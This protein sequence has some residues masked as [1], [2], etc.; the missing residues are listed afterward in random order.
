MIELIDGLEYIKSLIENSITERGEAGKRS[1][2]NSSKT[3]N[4]LHEVV[5]SDLIFNGI[6]EDLIKPK[7][8]TSKPEI[9]LAG[10]LK[11]KYQDVCVFPND[12]FKPIPEIIDYNGLH[13]GKK[14]KYGEL[15]S[16]HIL[17]INL[18]SQ[19]SSLSKNKDTMFE[20]TYAEPLNLH[21]RLPKMVLG[22]VYLLSA[23]ELD[24]KAV[25]ENLVSYKPVSNSS[26]N[27]LQEYIFGFSA[28]NGR[29]N[30]GDDF[31]KYE[32]VALLIVD[33]S[34]SPIKIYSSVDELIA[35]GFL[36]ED[37]GCSLNN[38]TYTNFIEDLLKSYDRRFG[39]GILS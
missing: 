5:K 11:Y 10:F 24:S 3:I 7:L 21:R 13:S 37:T 17:S 31:F 36:Y 33:F 18:R 27:A 15:F 20:R 35:D 23:R 1:V 4:V 2:I 34:C 39:T 9:R 38:M 32:R 25:K 28:L 6:K 14:D 16:E 29:V 22:E 19:L 12:S 30:Q 8:G 26:K